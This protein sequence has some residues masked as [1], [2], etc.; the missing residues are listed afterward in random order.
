MPKAPYGY[1]VRPQ[2]EMQGLFLESKPPCKSISNDES[3]GYLMKTEF[4]GGFDKC[5]AL[6][7]LTCIFTYIMLRSICGTLYLTG[8]LVGNN[9]NCTGIRFP[10]PCSARVSM[11]STKTGT[12]ADSAAGPTL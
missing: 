5:R 8:G 12:L 6:G 3:N 4:Y 9:R 11:T 10:F 7:S 2:L 1:Y